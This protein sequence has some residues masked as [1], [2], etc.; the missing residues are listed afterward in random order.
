MADNNSTTGIELTHTD[1]PP[2]ALSTDRVPVFSVVRPNPAFIEWQNSPHELEPGEPTPEN[3]HEPTVSVSYTMPA[4]TNPGL[5][6]DYL[7]RA[8]ENA[9]L[10]ASWL[11]ELALGTEGY[12]ALVAE[13]SAEPDPD[14]AQATMQTIITKVAQRA[15]GGLGKA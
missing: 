14:A 12:D 9:D 1:A 7:K 15:L 10:A 8:R 4:K 3:P 2:W 5:A 6:L 11:L 13:L